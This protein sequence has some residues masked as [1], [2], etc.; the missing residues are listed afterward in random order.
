MNPHVEPQNHEQPSSPP[1]N[2]QRPT[3]QFKAEEFNFQSQINSPSSSI[4]L[5]QYTELV[6]SSNGTLDLTLIDQG[7]AVT[8]LFQISSIS[9]P[10]APEDARACQAAPAR[11]NVAEV[12][13]TLPSGR[14]R[15]GVYSFS[16]EISASGNEAIVYSRQ[17]YSDPAHGQLGCQ[18]WGRGTLDVA[19]VSYDANGNLEYLD[20][21]V[22]RECR[23][24][25]PLPPV[26]PQDGIPQTEVERMTSYTYRASWRG[27]YVP[28]LE[29]D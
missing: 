16:E 5:E 12:Q 24:T 2:Y 4:D 1:S 29:Q 10:C 15:P 7:D 28:V 14:L 27:R 23:Q 26:L 9:T 21:S 3:V 11:G 18:Q 22:M 25:T 13:L 8:Y 20:A 17:L 6:T 19:S